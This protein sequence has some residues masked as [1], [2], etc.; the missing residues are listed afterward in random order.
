MDTF[1]TFRFFAAHLHKHTGRK[2]KKEGGKI[3]EKGKYKCITNKQ[4]N[5]NVE[6]TVACMMLCRM[7][8]VCCSSLQKMP[9]QSIGV[10]FKR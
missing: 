1:I 4:T 6:A 8:D 5:K 10:I 3:T 2:S 7:E 9:R